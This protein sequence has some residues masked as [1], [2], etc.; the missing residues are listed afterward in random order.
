MAVVELDAVKAGNWM[1]LANS[2]NYFNDSY[3]GV[4]NCKG[5]EILLVRCRHNKPCMIS[6]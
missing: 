1:S 4:L 3:L 6:F 5:D 2:E